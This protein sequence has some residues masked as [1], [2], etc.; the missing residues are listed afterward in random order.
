MSSLHRPLTHCCVTIVNYFIPRVLYL[1]SVK[2]K[3]NP[4]LKGKGPPKHPIYGVTEKQKNYCELVLQGKS[5]T[6][7]VWQAFN[8]SNR[9]YASHYAVK[10]W[11]S[12]GCI[13]YIE[14]RIAEASIPDDAIMSL[15]ESLFASKTVVFGE[16]DIRDVS[17]EPARAKARDQA[18]RI[19]GAYA[20]MKTAADMEAVENANP[21]DLDLNYYEIRYVSDHG[22]MPPTQRALK[23]YKESIDISAEEVEES[24]FSAT[25]Q[26]PNGDDI[27]NLKRDYPTTD[28]DGPPDPS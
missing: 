26:P 8:F 19:L 5:K 27:E 11:K 12:P 25:P 18:F 28:P 21:K 1:L 16:G 24:V 6:E 3:G 15:K 14:R 20:D 10:L 17:D 22:K 2:R 9:N 23:E 4:N 13:A 7:A